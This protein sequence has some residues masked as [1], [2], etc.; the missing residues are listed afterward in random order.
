MSQPINIIIADDHPIFRRGLNMI[1]ASDPS[2]KVLAEASNGNEALALIQ[3]LKP[4][5]AVLDIDMPKK[6]GF[7]VL[8]EVQALSLTTSI[9]FLTMH[10]DEAL[11]NG[12]LDLGVKGYLLKDSAVSEIID[13][14]KAVA[15]GENFISP[16][17]STFLI[18]RSLKNNKV[19][20]N[21]TL[22]DKLTLSEQRILLLIAEDKT[23]KEIADV[24]YISTRT[25]ENHRSH[26]CQKLNLQ[27]TN[28]LLRFALANKANLLK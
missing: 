10:K 1:I 23:T 9:I 15:L 26:I 2:L 5:V 4:Q 14:V 27:G 11:F 6:N 28:A 16:T 24:L 3:Q 7:D 25:V 19:S 22:L 20:E 12:A 21:K 17:L 8:K 13:S 18:N